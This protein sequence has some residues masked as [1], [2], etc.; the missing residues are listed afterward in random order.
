MK[1]L[2]SEEARAIA[3]EATKEDAVNKSKDVSLADDTNTK[4]P[5]ELA[6]K[7]YVDANAALGS[8]ALAVEISRATDAEKANA[9]AIASEAEMARAEELALNEKLGYEIFK[10]DDTDTKLTNDLDVE[11]SRAKTVEAT[12]EDAVN[13][14]TDINLTDGTN[15]KF[16]TELAVKTSV[17]TYSTINAIS[18][19]TADYTALIKDY[20]ILSNNTA[21][22][23]SLTLPAASAATGKIYVIRKTDETTHVLTINPAVKM[24]ETTVVS[25]LNFSRTIRIQ[26]NGASWYVID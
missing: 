21:S 24:T 4:F 18:T 25:S 12:K 15:T 19:I 23:F 8:V 1:N 20:T 17:D 14:S 22:D 10:R 11:I 5:T 2:S 6:V 13:K 9:A 7:T 3:A 16:P 26:S